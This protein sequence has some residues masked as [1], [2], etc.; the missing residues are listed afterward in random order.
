[1]HI[2]PVQIILLI[3]VFYVVLQVIRRTT[4]MVANFVIF[5]LVL[6]VLMPYETRGLLGGL[7]RLFMEIGHR[8]AYVLGWN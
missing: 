3:I 5:V 6:A 2:D 1:M 4:R 8:L 7:T